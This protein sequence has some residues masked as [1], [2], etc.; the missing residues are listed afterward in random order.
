MFMAEKL[1]LNAVVQDFLN[2]VVSPPGWRMV[3]DNNVANARSP[4]RQLKGTESQSLSFV[5][6][7][8]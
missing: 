7:P 2:V 8:I 6:K 3:T 1:D 5:I 4:R